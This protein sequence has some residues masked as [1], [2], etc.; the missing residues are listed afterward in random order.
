[1]RDDE[2]YYDEDVL[3]YQHEEWMAEQERQW[4]IQEQMEE[5]GYQLQLDLDQEDLRPMQ[6]EYEDRLMEEYMEAEDDT[7]KV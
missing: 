6:E 2:C 3:A 4:L 5:E 7:G 1:M